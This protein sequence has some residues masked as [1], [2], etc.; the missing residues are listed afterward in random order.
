MGELGGVED[1][2]GCAV[3]AGERKWK[4]SEL[5]RPNEDVPKMRMGLFPGWQKQYQDKNVHTFEDLVRDH[6][7]WVR[8]NSG[9]RSRL[10]DFP[11]ATQF[12]G[13]YLK[14]D[15]VI[16]LYEGHYRAAAVALAVYD[17][18]PIPFLQNPT[19]ALTVVEG[20]AKPLLDHLFAHKSE[21]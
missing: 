4:L 17:G 19:I 1:A 10:A 18:R 21:A 6:T 5:M 20:D 8:A 13:L 2:P 16:V 11:Q 7:A 9:V 15:D 3:W 14:Q 12:I